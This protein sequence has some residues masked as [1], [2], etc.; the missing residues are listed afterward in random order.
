MDIEEAEMLG[1]FVMRRDQTCRHHV[2]RKPVA[3]HGALAVNVHA[4]VQ[5]RWRDFLMLPF[6]E[7]CADLDPNGI[8]LASTNTFAAGCIASY[9]S[10]HTKLPPQQVAILHKC[11]DDVETALSADIPAEVRV[12]FTELQAIA[13]LVISEHR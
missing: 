6:P 8:C 10:S 2:D 5:H 7:N 1:A 12:Y 11:S 13:R 4:Q 3:R 9:V